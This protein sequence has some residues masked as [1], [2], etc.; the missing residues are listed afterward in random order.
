MDLLF[1]RLGEYDASLT[2]V[3]KWAKRRSEMCSGDHLDKFPDILF[4]LD[5]NY[6]V[7][8]S[9]FEKIITKNPRHE[10]LSGGHIV[11]GVLLTTS[12]ELVASMNG[13]ENPATV[14]RHIQRLMESR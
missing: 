11:D 3:V 9:V 12:Q 6:G 7:F 13:P 5:R 1:N 8:W 10:T 2:G 4:E 14:S